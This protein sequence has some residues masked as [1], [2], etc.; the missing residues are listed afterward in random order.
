M[1]RNKKPEY[2]VKGALKDLSVRPTK[3][4]GQNFVVDPSVIQDIVNFGNPE[5]HENIVE[6]G[7]G[8]GALTG[9]LINRANTLSLVE[10]E[11]RFVAELKI[12]F[13][14]ANIIN[15]D[16]RIVDYNQFDGIITV[17][18]NIPYV[19]STEIV[20]HL[21][22]YP[23]KIKRIVLLLQKEF[24]QRM[25]AGP[26]SRTYG[27]LSIMTQLHCSMR[28]GPIIKGD[29][30]YPTTKVESQVI[31]C[32]FRQKALIDDDMFLWFSKI[33]RASFSQRRKK[34]HN[35]LLSSG[36]FTKEK[37]E[38]GFKT[39]NIDSNRRAETLSIDEFKLLAESLN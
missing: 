19:F 22:K 3:E 28:L 30:F 18:G 23:A 20:F 6:I 34:L 38:S 5:K 24:A 26:G 25:A 39:A 8:L 9:E 32:T 31:E 33:V 29:R 17:F 36:L 4:R 15:S 7:P 2:I 37:L 12:K 11:P 16:A 14:S 35:S 1:K 10:I 21:L 27:I 13:P